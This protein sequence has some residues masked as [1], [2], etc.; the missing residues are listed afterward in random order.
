MPAQPDQTLG[1]VTAVTAVLGSTG[2]VAEAVKMMLLEGL[3]HAT[4]E[5][6]SHPFQKEFIALAGGVLEGCQQSEVV[7]LAD[8]EAELKTAESTLETMKAR[9]I[10][11]V[12]ILEE[13]SEVAA[14]AEANEA[15]SIQAVEE[16]EKEHAATER[17]GEAFL[18]EREDMQQ[19][20]ARVAAITEGSLKM[21]LDGGW[22]DEETMSGANEAVQGL[23]AEICSDKVVLAAASLALAAK[24][25]SRGA[26][27]SMTINTVSKALSEHL[28]AIGSKLQASEAEEIETKAEILGLWAIADCAR[29][30]AAAAGAARADAQKQQ[31]S[32]KKEVDIERQRAQAQDAE[33]A[34]RAT[35]RSRVMTRLAEVDE[36]VAATGRLAASPISN[37]AADAAESMA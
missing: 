4:M 17:Q 12:K 19:D 23:L 37:E 9:E 20:R 36:A 30:G 5:G 25:A 7:A 29:D 24:P 31:R 2:Q 11:A 16:A 34:E 8:I 22:D 26:F 35:K 33:V 10:D 6:C 18:K 15:M 32:A 27:D 21:L 3:P 1:D 28:A 14:T 13:T